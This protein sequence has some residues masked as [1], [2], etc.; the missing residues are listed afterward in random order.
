MFHSAHKLGRETIQNVTLTSKQRTRRRKEVGVLA[1][2]IDRGLQTEIRRYITI[3]IVTRYVC[4][5]VV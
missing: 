4:Y 3:Y 2:S 5:A 1:G